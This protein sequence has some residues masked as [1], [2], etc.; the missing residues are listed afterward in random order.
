MARQI[1]QAR[2][3]GLYQWYLSQASDELAE[4]LLSPTTRGSD[5]NRINFTWRLL[6][7]TFFAKDADADAD[8]ELFADADQCKHSLNW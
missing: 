2:E 7:S 3:R 6:P 4:T 8:A 5:L 1:L